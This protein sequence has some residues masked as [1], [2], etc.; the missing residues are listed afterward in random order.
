MPI[1]D[2]LTS[3]KM[4]RSFEKSHPTHLLSTRASLNGRVPIIAVSAS[5]VERERHT[6]IDTGFDGWILKPIAFNRLS[7][8]MKGIIEAETRKK[9][10]YRAGVWEY[11]G[12]FHAAQKD[13]FAA[14]TTP[15]EEVPLN[16]V[17]NVPAPEGVKAAAAV[18]DPFVREEDSSEQTREQRRLEEVGA[19][20]A[21]S[22]PEL[23][24]KHDRS[25][26]SEET[27]TQSQIVATPPPIE[28]S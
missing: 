23:R 4:I 7:E 11:G 15:S 17:S 21:A 25:N 13:V 2:G 26:S 8:I 24:R 1:V 19:P 20:K 5:L 12:W 9:N 27:V 22:M 16:Q 28:D 3:A 14:D 6:Y 18:D 10:L